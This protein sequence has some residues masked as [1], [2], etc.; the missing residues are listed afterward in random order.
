[1]KKRIFQ[2]GTMAAVLGLTLMLGACGTKQEAA[3]AAEKTAEETS[4]DAAK[5]DAEPETE[6]AAAEETEAA[7][8]GQAG[9]K[10]ENKIFSFVM[11]EEFAGIYDVEYSEEF[12]SI[13]IYDKQAKEAELGGFAFAICAFEN[14]GD[15]AGMPGGGKIGE[16]TS[17]DGTLYDIVLA[18]PTDVQWDA[19]EPEGKTYMKLYEAADSVAESVESTDGGSYVK[20]AGMKGEELYGEVL[21]KYRAALEEGWEA[22][23]LEEEE[24]SPMYYVIRQDNPEEVM[25]R[26]GFTYKDISGD[27]IEELLIGEIAED[28]W[29]GV[30]YDIYTIVD[31]KPAHVLSGWDRNRYFVCDDFFLCN[32]YSEGADLSGWTISALMDNSTET[33]PQVMFKMDG[34]ENK[35]QPWFISYG[36]EEEWENVTEEEWNEVRERFSEYDRFDY[37]P[38]AEVK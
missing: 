23:K 18:G 1:M 29:K 33:Y 30:I 13:G 5:E 27:G 11:P 4:Q 10:L 12:N 26:I 17:G 2:T 16:L 19:A 38:M 9:E 8:A 32:E 35:E 6:E 37:T 3:P 7:E 25:N 15:Y 28:D 34:Y 21:Q 22:G 20:G 24:M 31:R 36:P 14:P